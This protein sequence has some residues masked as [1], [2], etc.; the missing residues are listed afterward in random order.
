MENSKIS[1]E[2]ICKFH[3]LGEDEAATRRREKEDEGLKREE[4]D[5]MMKTRQKKKRRRRR[6]R[7]IDIKMTKHEQ[8]STTSKITNKFRTFEALSNR[9]LILIMLTQV[10]VACLARERPHEIVEGE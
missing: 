7:G 3:R 9:L 10:Y 5:S 2:A 4:D 1:F 8:V 6:E